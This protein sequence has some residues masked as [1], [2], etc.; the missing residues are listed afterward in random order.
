MK[1]LY[2][3]AVL[4]WAAT[5]YAQPELDWIRLYDGGRYDYFTDIYAT[6]DGGYAMCGFQS[7]QFRS[8]DSTL[9][10]WVVKIDGEGRREW[11]ARFGE[12]NVADEATSLIETDDNAFLIAGK[13]NGMVAALLLNDEGELIWFNTYNEYLSRAEAVIELK[14]G[15]FV[16]AGYASGDAYLLCINVEGDILWE[17]TYGQANRDHFMALRETNDGIVVSGYSWFNRSPYYEVLVVKVDFDGEQVWLRNHAPL[18]QACQRSVSMV[19]RPEGGFALGGWFWTGDG[20]QD[21]DYLWMHIDAEGNMERFRRIDMG[22]RGSDRCNSISRAQ[23]DGFVLVGTEANTAMPQALRTDPNGEIRWI[24]HY[25]IAD[26][27]PGLVHG[28][29]S[30]TSAIVGHDNSIVV[31]GCAQAIDANGSVNGLVMKLE[32]ESA[33]IQFI[34]WQPHDTTLTVLLG[35]TVDFSVTVLR[36]QGAGISYEWTLDDTLFDWD[37]TATVIFDS[38]DIPCIQRVR[39]QASAL[40]ETIAIT[41]TVRVSD[42]AIRAYRPENYNLIIRRNTTVNFALL[43]ETLDEVFISYL[44]TFIDREDDNRREVVGLDTSAVRILFDRTGHFGVIGA[45]YLGQS[46]DS[47]M[48]NIEVRGLIRAF[49][50]SSEMISLRAGDEVSFWVAPFE[51]QQESRLSYRWKIDEVDIIDA[52]TSEIRL[53]FPDTGQFEVIVF[54]TDSVQVDSLNWELVDADSQRW[55]VNALVPNW[56]DNSKFQIPNSKLTVSPNPFNS[57]AEVAIKL[58][59][60]SD[61]KLQMFDIHG[62]GVRTLADCRFEAGHHR[63]FV[64]GGG[65]PAGIYI[66]RLQ[67]ET[68]AIVFKAVQIK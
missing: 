20:S 44:W 68:K 18:Q 61:V 6:S 10:I 45:A 15:E 21:F 23:P 47:V 60:A 30:F 53:A 56:I 41:W 35:D 59:R 29:Q 55:V 58:N 28:R 32:P 65:L 14:S 66:L 31:C 2:S 3:L 11:S 19:S 50:P 26:M 7:S 46:T 49:G 38:L 36:P 25:R 54:V 39:C 24:A 43:A 48:W 27:T 12:A 9:D 8:P 52:D 51:V 33:H 34:D 1:A 40:N 67:T 22:N 5:V 17:R 42:L 63:L 13:S 57:K 16:L 37:S 62:R 4:L 64:D